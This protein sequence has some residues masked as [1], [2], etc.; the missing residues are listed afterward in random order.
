MTL[1]KCRECEAEVDSDA[2]LCPA[3]G[4]RLRHRSGN[5]ARIATYLLV[6]LAGLLAIAIY[7]AVRTW[8]SPF[9]RA[10]GGTSLSA[11]S[12]AD[13]AAFCVSRETRSASYS[14]CGGAAW[15]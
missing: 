3:C 6:V 11:D 10:A 2:E 13:A 14:R 7:G 4:F 12:S 8:G 15:R 1:I 9:A 5:S